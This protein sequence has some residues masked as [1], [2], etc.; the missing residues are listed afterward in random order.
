MKRLWLVGLVCVLAALNGCGGCGDDPNAAQGVPFGE[1]LGRIE[2]DQDVPNRAARSACSV[3]RARPIAIRLARST[4]TCSIPA[5][6]ELENV[7]NETESTIPAR[8]VTTASNSGFI[9]DLGAVRIARPGQ[10]GGH[11]MAPPGVEIPYAVI[12]VPGFPAA[13]QPDPVKKAYL[14]NRV[15]AGTHDVVLT[16]ADGDVV[17]PN[18]IVRP[19]D[20]TLNVNFDLANLQ[21]HSVHVIGKAQVS[22]MANRN[23]IIVELVE[24]WAVRSRRR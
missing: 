2:I 23:G 19:D 3:H 6:W 7:A 14:L 10:V 1:V 16:T 5:N 21:Q 17:V 20:V 12:T 8:R 15:P 22:G 18:V 9:T 4:S 13:T 11:I 24:P